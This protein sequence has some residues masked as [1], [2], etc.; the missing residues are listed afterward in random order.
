MLVGA[1]GTAVVLAGLF[2]WPDL[3]DVLVPLGVLAAL[4]GWR[5]RWAVRPWLI[6][7]DASAPWLTRL[8]VV[9]LLL[10]LAFGIAGHVAS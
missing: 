9:A 1:L 8:I 3:V 5:V 2:I 6:P 7:R 4:V 10:W